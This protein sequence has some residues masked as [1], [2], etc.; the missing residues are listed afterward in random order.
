MKIETEVK[1]KWSDDD[2]PLVMNLEQAHE[3]YIM[4]QRMFNI[5]YTMQSVALSTLNKEALTQPRDYGFPIFNRK[6]NDKPTP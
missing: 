2:E 4:L 3:L 5:Q 1:I 6:K